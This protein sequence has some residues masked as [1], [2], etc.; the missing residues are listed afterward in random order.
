MIRP[1]ER[2]ENPVTGEVLI[3]HETAASTGGDHVRVE[4]IVQPDGFVAA[5]HVHPG[6]DGA[7]RRPQRHARCPPRPRDRA[8]RRRRHDRGPAG[9]AAPVLEPGRRR[10]A[11]PL[12]DPAGARVRVADRDDVHARSRGQ[13]RQARSPRPAPAR[14]HR[15][16]PL[17]H[18]P[19]S[20]PARAFP[21]GGVAV[22]APLGRAL[23]YRATVE[24]RQARGRGPGRT[25]D[26]GRP[27][28]S[29]TGRAA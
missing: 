10:G 16:R 29:P 22:G 28:G 4:T 24:R 3:F 1:G 6:P 2:L 7:L 5:A 20:V 19:A 13:D 14:S 17:R 11:L 21:A 25:Y 26:R 9:Y 8:C 18:R 23:G 12:P 15:R 27:Y